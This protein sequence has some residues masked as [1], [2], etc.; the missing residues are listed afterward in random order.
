M[1]PRSIQP[2]AAAAP[3]RLLLLIPA[4]LLGIGSGYLQQ[5]TPVFSGPDG[6]DQ[7]PAYI[8]LLNGLS[9]DEGLCPPNVYHPGTPLQVLTGAVILLRWTFDWVASGFSSPGIVEMVAKAP[10]TFISTVSVLLLLLNACADYAF[11]RRVLQASGS[12]GLALFAQCAPLAFWRVAPRLVYL[13]PEALQ[14][15]ASLVLL[16]LLTPLIVGREPLPDPVLD[17]LSWRAGLV[18]GFGIAV[19]VT[20]APMLCLLLLLPKCSAVRRGL[21]YAVFAF[22]VCV[23]PIFKQLSY[24]TF[25]I[26]TLLRHSGRYG[27]G[28]ADVVNLATMRGNLP[29]LID[30]F[31]FFFLIFGLLVLA[32]AWRFLRRSRGFASTAGLSERGELQVTS[33]SRSDA[34]HISVRVPLSIVLAC[35]IQTVLVLKHF[36]AHY[37]VP[38][39]PLSFAGAIWLIESNPLARHHPPTRT[40]ARAILLVLGLAMSVIASGRALGTLWTGR[41]ASDASVAAVRQE[42]GRHPGSLLIGTSLC[43]LPQC[44]LAFG[45]EY[46][47]AFEVEMAPFVGDFVLFDTWD[48]KLRV[49]GTLRWFEPNTIESELARGREILLLAPDY[50]RITSFEREELLRTP[51]QSLYRIHG[52]NPRR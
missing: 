30:L 28:P 2:L 26:T 8:Y 13:S 35:T 29:I 43:H 47:P 34:A 48:S 3:R 23:L 38:V 17:R 10:E 41:A 9:L 27:T 37:M 6:F 36:A 4:L 18:C 42:L 1:R 25:W 50:P 31:P 33:N 44:A 24:F 45:L 12:T 14:I 7:D 20:F 39:L 22:L 49:F 11:G 46:S 5:I 15:A 16:A 40:V 21:L 51:L 19:K 52:A 32:L